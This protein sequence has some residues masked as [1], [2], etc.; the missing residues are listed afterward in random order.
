MSG[1]KP[2]VSIGLPV[3]NGDRYIRETLDSILSQSFSDFELII[4]DNCSSDETQQICEEYANKNSRII[5][6][7]NEKNLGAAP[8]YNL[9]FE[10]SSGEYFKW[11]DYDDI[12]SPDFISRCVE[13]LDSH[14]EV[15][16]CFPR[17][18]FID[19]NGDFLQ[20]YDPQPDVSSSLPQVRFE[21]LL[22]AHDHRLAQVSGL[23]RASVIGKTVMHGSYPCSDEVLMAQLA[24][25]G[26]FHEIPERLFFLRMHPN[27]SS[28]GMLASERARVHFFDT[29]L[30]GKAVPIKWL[31]FKNCIIAINHSPI[32]LSQRI[33]CYVSVLRWLF[34]VPNFRSFV[35]DILLEFH[36]RIPIFPKMYQETLDASNS[37]D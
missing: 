20:D 14:P 10:L 34:R 21:K 33:F 31:Y 27:M 36:Q 7:R 5:Y 17:A 28:K 9:A 37:I 30:K 15:A 4:A 18:K 35:K 6:H 1:N 13:V 3:Y 26:S 12:L 32:T 25:F 19:E 23:M 16:V 2:R 24:L 29:S 8:N 22:L 11:A